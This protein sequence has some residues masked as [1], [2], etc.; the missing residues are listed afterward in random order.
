MA[1]GPWA[2]HAIGKPVRL[3]VTQPVDHLPHV[4]F[5]VTSAVLP[6]SPKEYAD[7]INNHWLIREVTGI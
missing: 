6:V 2:T 7:A 5:A 4:H 3:L 1:A